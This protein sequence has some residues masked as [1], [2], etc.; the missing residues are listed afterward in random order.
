M[1]RLVYDPTD[2]EQLE[3]IN[4]VYRRLREELM[5][6][7]DVERPKMVETVSWAAKN[8]DRSENA[9]YLSTELAKI[10][11]IAPARLPAE[12]PRALVFC[13]GVNDCVEENATPRVPPDA[14]LAHAASI[15][16]DRLG[17]SRSFSRTGTS[18]SAARRPSASVASCWVGA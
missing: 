11:G 18:P 1:K 3:N 13:F 14:T 15:L 9:D 12:H 16:T 7:L 8:G 6:L 2:P 5:T 10:P 4:D 17:S